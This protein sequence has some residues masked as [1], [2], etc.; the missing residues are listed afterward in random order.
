MV[1]EQ[2]QEMRIG[3]RYEEITR[4]FNSIRDDA[5]EMVKQVDDGRISTMERLSNIWQK[6][7][8]GDIAQR[9]DKIRGMYLSVSRDTK[10]QI[11]RED[12]ILEAYRDFRGALKEA[13]VL[14]LEVLRTAESHLQ[15]AKERMEKAAAAVENA[16]DVDPAERAR[17]ELARDEALRALQAEDARYQI[18]KDLSDNL[19]VLYNTSEVIMARLVQTTSAKQ[20]V[21]QQSVSFFSTNE[22]VL[23]ALTATF[24]GLTGLSES[25]RTLEGLKAG[26]SQKSDTLAEIG[27]KVQEEALRAGYGPTIQAEAVKR[28]VDSVVNYQERSRDIIEEMRRAATQNSEEIPDGRRGRQTPD[29]APRPEGRRAAGPRPGT[30]CRRRPGPM[31]SEA[32]AAPLPAAAPS[33]EPPGEPAS[34]DETMLAMDVVDTL[35]H[36][37]RVVERELQGDARRERLKE[38][39]RDIYRTQGIDLPER[40][41]DQGVAAL[42]QQ[43]FAYHPTPPSFSRS[44]ATAWATRARWGRI[45]GV[46]LLAIILVA[47]GWWFGVR[48]PAQQRA[49]AE[50][51]EL[52]VDLPRELRAERDRV[53]ATTQNADARAEAERLE[54]EG[55]AAARAGALCGCPRPAR[56]APVAAKPT[57]GQLHRPHR[58]PPRRAFGRMARAP[59]QFARPQLLPD[60]GGGRF[61]RASR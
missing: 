12:R 36:A 38:R 32:T 50:H 11:E 40:I 2:V 55:E 17:L 35:R 13:E 18:A 20:R 22:L 6:V 7:T 57:R 52:T 27:G 53:L 56:L 29:G 23:T 26:V 3:E 43:R 28:L 5:R 21:Y 8:R 1:R 47:G 9:F 16:K 4:A 37:D 31:P 33:S 14:A 34:L 60:R 25:T 41:L 10:D 59:G 39:L 49:E 48:L 42:E 45:T 19:T 58:Q 61:F 15:A 54:N 24:A 46:I 44:L 30:R 51:T